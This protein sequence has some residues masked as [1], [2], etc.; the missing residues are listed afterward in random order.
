MSKRLRLE[1]KRAQEQIAAPPVPSG[2]SIWLISCG[3]ALLVAMVQ[4]AD[5]G[6]GDNLTGTAILD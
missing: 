1:D 6:N 5:L 3:L 2:N 4:P